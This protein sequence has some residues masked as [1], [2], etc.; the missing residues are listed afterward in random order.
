MFFP[1]VDPSRHQDRDQPA[2]NRP[3]APVISCPVVRSG[4]KIACCWREAFQY[5]LPLATSGNLTPGGA[6]F[7]Q[8]QPG[9][10]SALD[11]AGPCRVQFSSQ[12]RLSLFDG[13][14]NLLVQSDGQSFGQP[15]PVIDQHVSQGDDVVEVQSLSGCGRLYAVNV[16]DTGVRPVSNARPGPQFFRG[17]AFAP[18]P[19]ATSTTTRSPTSWH[20]TASTWEPGMGPSSRP[21]PAEHS[22]TPPQSLL[23][24]AIAVGDFNGDHN[25][26]V[27]VALE[28][29]DSIAIELGNGDGTFQVPETIGLPAGKSA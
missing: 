9:T 18:L 17:E 20:P 14:G 19:S 1:Q 22:S 2:Q 6:D 23:P 25:L 10:D 8:V 16:V 28:A 24:T 12:L 21:R 15:D 26:D 13:Q 5:P 4:S 11:R 3:L 27:A 29:T 7:Y